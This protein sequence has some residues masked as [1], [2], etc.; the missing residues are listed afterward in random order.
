MMQRDWLDVREKIQE[1]ISE[2]LDEWTQDDCGLG[3]FS[4]K[5]YVTAD[6]VKFA[7]TYEGDDDA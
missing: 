4:I 6:G 3:V 1:A 7:V 5:S 2:I